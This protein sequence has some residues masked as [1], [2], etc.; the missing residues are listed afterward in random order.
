MNKYIRRIQFTGKSTYII[1]LPK[2]WVLGQGLTQGEQV[3]VEEIGSSLV[4]KPFKPSEERSRAIAVIDIHETDQP[5]AVARRV[6][7]AYVMGYDEILLKSKNSI[8]P[9]IRNIVRKTILEKLLGAD[10]VSEDRSEIRVEVL[11]SS[12]NIGLL[13]AS[14]RLA[15]VVESVVGDTCSALLKGDVNL[16]RAIVEE[17]DSVDRV[18]FYTNRLM[19]QLASGRITSEKSAVTTLELLM[20]KSLSKLLE[21]IGDHAVNVAMNIEG[22]VKH[23]DILE[24]VTDFCRSSLDVYRSSIEAFF[25]GNP[26]AIDNVAIRVEDIKKREESFLSEVIQVLESRE[27]ASLRVILESLRRI[28]EYSRDI[29]EIALDMEL[30]RVIDHGEE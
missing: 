21:R 28:S 7:G 15:R 14:R 11:L 8:P 5:D 29:A 16:A 24:K 17:D 13:D 27:L 23:V 6:I 19:N 10:I 9:A 1:S 2:K 26:Y 30:Y 20:Y 12:R 4:I 22:L 3:V 25:T 18:F